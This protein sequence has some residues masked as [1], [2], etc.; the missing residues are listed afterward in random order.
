M[1]LFTYSTCIRFRPL[2]KER[3]YLYFVSGNGCWTKFVGRRGGRQFVTLTPYCM[4]R[5]VIQRQLLHTLGFVNEE[6]R[7][8]RDQYVRI[9][10]QN[11]RK[12]EQNLLLHPHRM[13]Y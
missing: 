13:I 3:D 9:N 7:S 11:V 8:D 2:T 6:N 12:G 10:Y 5:P 1:E 4:S